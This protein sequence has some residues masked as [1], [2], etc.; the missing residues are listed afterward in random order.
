[1]AVPFIL[2]SEI[3]KKDQGRKLGDFVRSEL[4][5]SRRAIKAIKFKGGTFLVNGIPQN[6]TYILKSGDHLE[7]QFPLE[8]KSETLS[9]EE[10]PLEI[11]F[12]DAYALVINKEA[13]IPT[14]PSYQHFKGTLANGVVDYLL[15]KGE[16]GA[17]HP[18]TR[19]DRET[20]GLVLM[21]KHGHVHDLFSRLQKER[22][23]HRR[24][25][26]IVH[27]EIEDRFG[28]IDAPIGRK[29]GSIIER[30]VSEE[31][32]P[33]ITHYEV[34]LKMKNTSLVGIELETGRTHQIRVHFSSIGHPLLGDD[35]YGGDKMEIARQALHARHLY[36]PHP[37]INEI[38]F[39]TASLPRDF[40][41]LIDKEDGGMEAILKWDQ[42]VKCDYKE[43]E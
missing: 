22:R 25:L 17:S 38:V 26:A 24:Y 43:S 3:H 21:A 20:S 7:V 15:K 34:L 30:C 37:L 16:E 31:G 33:A 2:K 41:S 39:C 11:V 28:T 42:K 4:Q 27:G 5:L 18:V 1:M 13:G 10:I 8:V 12:E 6:V 14:I 9:P 35:L 29:E 19:L 36:F 32:K 23:I 40:Q